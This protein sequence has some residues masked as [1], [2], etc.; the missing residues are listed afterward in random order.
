[1]GDLVRKESSASCYAKA[2][3]HRVINAVAEHKISRRKLPLDH[4]FPEIEFTLKEVQ[5]LDALIA[6]L[7]SVRRVYGE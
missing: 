7:Q 4:D 2:R 5:D 6:T 1:M 3:V